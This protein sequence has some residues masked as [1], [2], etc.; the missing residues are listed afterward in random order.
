[1]HYCPVDPC[2][3]PKVAVICLFAALAWITHAIVVISSHLAMNNSIHWSASGKIRKPHQPRG[4]VNSVRGLRLR[5]EHTRAQS[6]NHDRHSRQA[7][8]NSLN[9]YDS[10]DGSL[11][12]GTDSNASEP[13]HSSTRREY[14]GRENR[15]QFEYNDDGNRGI[16]K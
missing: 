2:E 6:I 4:G 13:D 14:K 10:E 3:S 8:Q 15:G 7:Q 1:M 12:S 9:R 11:Y 16:R 5:G